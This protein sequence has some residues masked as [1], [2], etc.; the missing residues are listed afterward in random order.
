MP[1]GAGS[2][3]TWTQQHETSPEARWSDE[4]GEPR[5]V[6]VLGS[7]GSIGSQALDIAASHPDRFRVLGLAAG[8]SAPA[9]LAAQALAHEVSAVAVT[10]STVVE[11]LQL[12]FYAEAQRRGY[13]RGEFRL[14][15]IFAGPDAVTELLEALP[16]DVVL[17]GLPGSQG[18]VPTL[19][20]L[21]SGAVL[22]LANKE[23]LV[24]GGPLVRRAAQPGQLVPV[25]SEHSAVAQALRGERAEDVDRLVLTAS[26]GP[27][28]GWTRQQMAGVTVHEALQH[29]TWSM[30]PLVT[31]NSATM[32]NKGLELVEAHLLFDIPCEQIDIVVHPQSV[33]HSMVTFVDGSTLAQASPPDMRLPIALGLSWPHR[34]PGA[35]AACRWDEAATWMFEP[36]D[37]EIFPAVELARHVGARGGCLPAVFNAANEELVHAFLAENISF[38]SVVNTVE[39]VVDA[40]GEWQAPPRDVDDIFAA[41]KW[42]RQRSR[43]IST[44]RK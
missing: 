9:D 10:K 42:A 28:R 25:D 19:R 18:L 26:G 6:L 33:V 3:N 4:K 20:A 17:N 38:T 13:A 29:P 43:E 36:V 31:I 22:A 40:A 11:D 30:G 32:V 41:E 23:S 35:A 39:K 37:H 34:V 1:A 15:R 16:A 21:E 44:G 12:A 14:P 8:G 7:T 27:F 5:T 2:G 24:A